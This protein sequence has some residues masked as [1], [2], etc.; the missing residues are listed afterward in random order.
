MER[1]RQQSDDGWI[2]CVIDNLKRHLD[3]D[4]AAATCID[5][6][7]AKGIGSAAT[8]YACYCPFETCFWGWQMR[9]VGQIPQFFRTKLV[10]AGERARAGN[11]IK[12][13]RISRRSPRARWAS[14]TESVCANRRTSSSSERFG[15]AILAWT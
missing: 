3:R 9:Q 12:F 14:L 2:V 6:F 4:K 1:T 5:Q 7:E 13:S 10:R 11:R 8:G 15:S